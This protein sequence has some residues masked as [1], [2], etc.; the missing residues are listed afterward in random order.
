MGNSI[1]K[2]PRHQPPLFNQLCPSL[3]LFANTWYRE[4]WSQ[5]HLEELHLHLYLFL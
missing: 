2:H 1:T 4:A 5:K 3:G